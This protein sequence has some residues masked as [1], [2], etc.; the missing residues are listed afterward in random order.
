MDYTKHFQFKKRDDG[1][2]FVCLDDHASVELQ[3]LIHDIH[4]NWFNECM[5]NDW[6]YFMT[7]EAFQSYKDEGLDYESFEAD[8]YDHDLATWF[9]ENCNQYANEISASLISDDC[10]KITSAIELISATQYEA[11]R[12]IYYAVKEFIE[13]NEV[14]NDQI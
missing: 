8:I 10:I 9:A 1:R 12:R 3:N 5:P 11:K 2:H 14:S 4:Y 13:Q 7:L 6:I